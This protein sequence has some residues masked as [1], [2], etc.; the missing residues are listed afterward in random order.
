MNKRYWLSSMLTMALALSVVLTSGVLAQGSTPQDATPLQNGVTASGEIVG[1]RAG[2]FHY[3]TVDYPGDLS[4]VTLRLDFEPADPVA[5]NGFGFKVYGENGYLIGEG[6]SDGLPTGVQEVR[7]S[8]SND[9]IWLVQ[10]YNY[11]PDRAIS[12]ELV[13]TGLPQASGTPEPTPVPTRSPA[14]LTQTESGTLTGSSA[15]A[16]IF[17]NLPYAADGSQIEIEMSYQPD[18]RVIARGVGFVVYG[19]QGEIA[20]G[21]GTGRPTERQATF[22]ATTPGNYII[23]VYNYIDNLTISFTIEA[24]TVSE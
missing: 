7:Y 3:Y 2:S 21:Q 19:P 24:M 8:D 4:V 22:S 11:L 17:Y 20:R 14:D 13:V 23:Q 9:D 16:Y 15:G 5:R 10:V 1:S 12:Y 18:N 6:S